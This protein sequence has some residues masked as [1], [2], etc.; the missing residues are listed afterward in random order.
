MLNYRILLRNKNT[1]K[2]NT[3]SS[4]IQLKLDKYIKWQ[5]FHT[6]KELLH[7]YGWQRSFNCRARLTLTETLCTRRMRSFP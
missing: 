1:S 3:L 4:H 2:I 5:H 7:D 6:P